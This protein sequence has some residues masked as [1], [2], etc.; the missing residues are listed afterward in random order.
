M[1]DSLL[2]VPFSN[3]VSDVDKKSIAVRDH[4]DQSRQGYGPPELCH[5]RI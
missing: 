4:R 3:T 2:E 1:E 5:S